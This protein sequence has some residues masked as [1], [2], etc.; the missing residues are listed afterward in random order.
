VLTSEL[1]CKS[2]TLS[3]DPATPLKFRMSRARVLAFAFSPVAIT[4]ILLDGMF[5]LIT[6]CHL[7]VV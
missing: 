6:T 4:K 1:F 3:A 7:P 5:V 2:G